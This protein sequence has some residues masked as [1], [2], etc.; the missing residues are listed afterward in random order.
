MSKICYAGEI[1]CDCDDAGSGSGGG[2]GTSCAA[3]NA[4]SLSNTSIGE[5]GAL[6]IN[7]ATSGGE[8]PLSY[9]ASSLPAW[10]SIN[11]STGLITGTAPDVTADTDFTG[12]TV[13]VT[14]S[15]SNGAQS[16]TSAAFTITVTDGAVVT[17][18][19]ITA[20]AIVTPSA[21]QSDPTPEGVATPPFT[22]L[23]N[24]SFDA[25]GG[26][27][28]NYRKR[29]T[30]GVQGISGGDGG[31]YTVDF[32]NVTYANSVFPP[33]GDLSIAS[34]DVTGEKDGSAAGSLASGL[35]NNGQANVSITGVNNAAHAFYFGNLSRDMTAADFGAD[36]LIG[37]SNSVSG[38]ITVTDGSGNS[39]DFTI[40]TTN[41]PWQATT[42]GGSG[43]GGPIN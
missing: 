8:A 33:T 26:G 12:I 25:S 1:Y 17:D 6:N 38:F 34:V 43:G 9:S 2:G 16:Q 11:A 13:T 15:C 36:P 19:P 41:D 22:E 28:M 10:A 4:P 20:T 35:P 14:D 32:S 37:F 42:A 21:A 23:L 40:P 27:A 31:P 30:A 29:L 5:G 3:L 18:P 39:E 7:A 24:V